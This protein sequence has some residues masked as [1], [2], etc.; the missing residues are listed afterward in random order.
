MGRDTYASSIFKTELGWMSVAV[1]QH[2]VVATSLPEPDYESAADAVSNLSAKP[3]SNGSPL[4]HEVEDLMIRYCAGENV[5][6]IHIPVDHGKASEFTMRARE[7]CRS[8][9]RGQTRSYRWLAEQA[10][11]SNGA[12]RAA[13]RVMATNPLPIIIPCHRVIGSDGKLHGFGG[14]IGLPLKAHLLEMESHNH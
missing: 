1:S 5:S 2:G 10:S 4:L 7:A 3:T 12:A 11:N 13:G 9:P 8:I 6:M 14:S